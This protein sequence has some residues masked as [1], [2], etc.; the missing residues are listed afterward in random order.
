VPLEKHFK[1]KDRAKVLFDWLVEAIWNDVGPCEI[2]SIPC[3]IHLVG[4]YDFLAAL[5]KKD[6]LE[7]RFALHR[8]LS[9]GRV[10]Q[11]VQTSKTGWAV[12]IVLGSESDVDEEVLGWL[13][14]SYHIRDK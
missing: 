13:R 9:H 1:N 10:S 5:P 4:T 8:Q 7:I 14:E 12:S 2:I 3:C 6:S 11:C